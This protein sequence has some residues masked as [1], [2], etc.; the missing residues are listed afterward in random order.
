MSIAVLFKSPWT[1][2]LC[3]SANVI[4]IAREWE[5]SKLPGPKDIRPLATVMSIVWDCVRF[6]PPGPRDILP[7]GMVISIDDWDCVLSKPAGPMDI[8][9]LAMVISI[10]WDCVWFKPPGPIDMCPLAVVMSIVCEW[11]WSIPSTLAHSLSVESLGIGTSITWQRKRHMSY[12]FT[13]GE[14]IEHRHLHHL[15]EQETYVIHIHSGWSHWA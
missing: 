3:P 1:L 15:A 7:E 8:R 11:V 9:P 13:Q 5:W 12:T 14:I 6:K 4:S 10:D 2:E